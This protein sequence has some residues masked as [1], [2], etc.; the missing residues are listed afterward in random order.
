MSIIPSVEC[1]KQSLV[2]CSCASIKGIKNAETNE[3][4]GGPIH[5]VSERNKDSI[6][7]WDMGQWYDILNKNLIFFFCQ[8]PESLNKV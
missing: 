7:N 5:K 8:C 1:W 2:N 4:N 6:R 3:D